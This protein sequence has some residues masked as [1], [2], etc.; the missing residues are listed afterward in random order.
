MAA[1][2]GL[3]MQGL[4]FCDQVNREIQ[5]VGSGVQRRALCC[6]QREGSYFKAMRCEAFVIAALRAPV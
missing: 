3:G 2:L 1:K 4:H 6:L 5:Y